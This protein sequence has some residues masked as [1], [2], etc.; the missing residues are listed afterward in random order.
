MK[1]QQCNTC[2]FHIF[3][4]H[5]TLLHPDQHRLIRKTLA[6]AKAALKSAS[7][8]PRVPSSVKS[9]AQCLGSTTHVRLK[10]YM[11]DQHPLCVCNHFRVFS[12][13]AGLVSWF[14][15]ALLLADACG[16]LLH[17]PNN[18]YLC[19]AMQLQNQDCTWVAFMVKG[20]L[21]LRMVAN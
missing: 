7:N 3:I 5:L 15:P 17:T 12:V 8:W 19:T 4:R 21:H 1:H 10:C 13:K 16:P 9:C 14:D 20:A 6:V 2:S 11:P 18:S